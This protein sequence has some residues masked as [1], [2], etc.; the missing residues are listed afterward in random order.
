MKILSIVGARP[1]FMKLAA[2]DWRFVNEFKSIEHLIVDTGQHYD[3]KMSSIFFE[4]LNISEP[5]RNLQVGSGTHAVQTSRMMTGIEEALLEIIPNHVIVYGDTNS[6]LAGAIAASKLNIPIS[7]VEAGLRSFNRSMPEEIN[8][9]LTDHASSLLFAPTRSALEQL[10]RENLGEKSFF[11]G[12]L[13]VELLNHVKKTINANE[14]DPYIFATIHRAENCADVDRITKIILKMR[15]SPIP[16]HLHCHPRL[17]QLLQS[18]EMAS[19]IGSLRILEPLDYFESLSSIFNSAGVVTDSG[20][21]QKEAYL[22]GKP[23][24][25]VRSETEWIE[26]IASGASTLDPELESLDE[27]WKRGTTNLI[28]SSIFGDGDTSRFVIQKILSES[29]K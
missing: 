20:G 21:V 13:T 29:S 2:M 22:A 6:T 8:R 24:L 16:V 10:Q 9:I 17:F 28:D 26:T 19:S 14:S 15:K 3:T 18:L 25:V 23:C 4:N 11:S 7:H 1:Q 5:Y 27:F 12:D